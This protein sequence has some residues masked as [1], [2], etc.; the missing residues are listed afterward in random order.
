[1]IESEDE[2]IESLEV[3]CPECGC[4]FAIDFIPK[5]CLCPLCNCLE[6]VCQCDECNIEDCTVTACIKNRG[7][8][9]CDK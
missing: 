6:S 8:G 9:R 3:T 1:M 2:E 4:Q 5:V 7:K